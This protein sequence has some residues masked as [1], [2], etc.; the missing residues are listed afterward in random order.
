MALG[1]ILLSRHMYEE[2]I[3]KIWAK[4]TAFI[5]NKI[6]ENAAEALCYA[7]VYICAILI[8]YALTK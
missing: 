8:V 7:L 1:G 4:M 2:L 6:G 3:A 5:E